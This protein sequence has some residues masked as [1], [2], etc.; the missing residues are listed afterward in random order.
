MKFAHPQWLWVLAALPVLYWVASREFARRARV[1]R[2]ILGEKLLPVL[3]PEA[4]PAAR[5][6][7]F[8][9]LLAATALVAVALARPQWGY[10]EETLTSS[11]LD[12]VVALDVS[13]SMN[14][15]DVVPSRL[16]KARHVVR[17]FLERL[18]GDRVGIVAFAAS[19]F[20]ASPLTNDTGY[21]LDVLETL[22]T[23]AI[24]NQGTDI[25]SA[26][27][28]A[29]K[30]LERGAEDLTD[31]GAGAGAQNTESSQAIV[32]I[33]D[34]EDLEE[35]IEPGVEAV[36]G[37]GAQVFVLGVGTAEGGPI[38]TRDQTGTLRGY[39][40]KPDGTAIVSAFRRDALESLARDLG[41]KYYD[42]SPGESEVD[43]ILSGLGALQRAGRAERKYQIYQERFQVPLAL[44]VLLLFI[45]LSLSTTRAIARR[46]EASRMAGSPVA[47]LGI[48][49]LLGVGMSEPAAAVE[50]EVYLKNEKG[51][52]ALDQG[53]VDLAKR[54]FGAAQA[55]DPES[56]ELMFNQGVVQLQEGD[57][58]GATQAFEEAAKLAEKAGDPALAARAYYNQGVVAQKNKQAEKAVSAFTRSI[59]SAMGAQDPKLE[60]EARKKLMVMAEQEKQK[61]EQQQQEGGEGEEQDQQEGQQGQNE[62]EGKDE[63][64][65]ERDSKGEG[66][67]DEPK[68][69]SQGNKGGR[70][71]KSK[72]L[73]PEDA[74]RVMGELSDKEQQL[75]SKLRKQGGRPASDGKDW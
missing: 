10:H 50:T 7:K 30:A 75:Q 46:R 6:R 14:V 29:A 9:V 35:G 41:G 43:D 44:A 72:K 63:K 59:R 8:K 66:G 12:I 51:L 2:A 32:L 3:A 49:F 24:A 67:K 13:N 1:L 69:F 71:F 47:T 62:G 65:E 42:V 57:F 45:E 34:G 4:D 40:K 53:R 16:K 20:L 5:P 55:R 19:N 28:T 60:E 73:T 26:L 74:E 27:S 39:K 58:A 15:E 25:G 70:E 68:K 36:K 61:Q 38:P 33:S 21:L 11:G 23:D 54:H 31:P 52:K 37:L 48:L 22:E 64:D 56:A 17:T 18:S